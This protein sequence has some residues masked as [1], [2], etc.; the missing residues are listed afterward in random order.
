MQKMSPES[1]PKDREIVI[2]RI[3]HAPPEVVFKAW[4]DAEQ[5]QEWW[6]PEGFTNPVCE[7]D[8]RVGGAWRIV[9]R[10]S[11]GT[12][13]PCGGIYQEIDQPGRLVFTNDATDSKGNVVLQGRTIVLFEAAPEGTKLTVTSR[14][15]ATVDYATVYLEGMH[16]GWSQSLGKLARLT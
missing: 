10:A 16:E 1:K 13:Y 6:G 14:A 8:F 11:D 3:Y 12:T 15:T 4:S 2:S 7:I 9:M 5:L